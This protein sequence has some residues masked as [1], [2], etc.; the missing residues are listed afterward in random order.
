MDQYI[1]MQWITSLQ[2]KFTDEIVKG[3]TNLGSEEFY[4]VSIPFIYWCVSKRIGFKLFYIFA[5]SMYFNTLLKLLVSSPRPIGVTGINS[6][7]TESI[8]KAYS[9]PNDSFPSGHMQGTTTFWVSLAY[10]I[11]RKFFWIITLTL[12]FLVGMSRMYLGLHWPLDIVA[13]LGIGLII[14]FAAVKIE[15]ITISLSPFFKSIL[16]VVIPLI[17][18]LVLP[19]SEAMRITGILLGASLGFL[20][21]ARYIQMKP[22]K[23][24]S[25]RLIAFLIGIS[26]LLIIKSGLKFVLPETELFEFIRYTCMGG[27]LVGISPWIFNKFNL[28]TSMREGTKCL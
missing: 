5:L 3:I 28:C 6:I 12:L 1:F 17:L 4:L 25:K 22:S 20:F 27:W 11:R 16:L 10:V 9:F 13:G 26:G 15:R 8:S 14:C 18:M 2:Q 19:I 7:Y 24:W 21:E 23:Q